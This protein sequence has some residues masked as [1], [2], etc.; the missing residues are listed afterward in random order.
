MLSC[1]KVGRL[2]LLIPSGIYSDKGAGS[3]RRLFLTKAR[4]GASVFISKRAVHLRH[5]PLLV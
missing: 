4:S 2:G 5:R 1:V 3:L